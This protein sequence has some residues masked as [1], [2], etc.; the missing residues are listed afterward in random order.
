MLGVVNIYFDPDPIFACSAIY[1]ATKLISATT[2]RIANNFSILSNSLV[3]R[4]DSKSANK[5]APTC[6]DHK[7]FFIDVPN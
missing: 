1:M 6:T 4:I 2:D 5:P 7:Y 3:T